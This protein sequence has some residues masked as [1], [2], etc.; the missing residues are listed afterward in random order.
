MDRYWIARKN[1]GDV[2]VEVPSDEESDKYGKKDDLTTQQNDVLE[3]KADLCAKILKIRHPRMMNRDLARLAV[4]YMNVPVQRLRDVYERIK[5]DGPGMWLEVEFNTLDRLMP[6]N[7]D[8]V[9][10]WL[11]NWEN[12]DRPA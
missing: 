2:K 4:P 9:N 10:Q 7:N 1:K 8:F 12:R 3:E 11:G 6:R 5:R